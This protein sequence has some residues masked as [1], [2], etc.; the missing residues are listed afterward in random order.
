MQTQYIPVLG[1]S[2]GLAGTSHGWQRLRANSACDLPQFLP[3]LCTSALLP[4][5]KGKGLFRAEL[6]NLFWQ[7]YFYQIS[8]PY[9]LPG[10]V[11]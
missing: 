4:A 1:V 7:G 3:S 9:R 8:F 2:R 6:H 5:V 10:A 11:P